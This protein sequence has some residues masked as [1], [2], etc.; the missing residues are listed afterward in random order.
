[1]QWKESG[2]VKYVEIVPA[3]VPDTC[4]RCRKWANKKI[5]LD[6]AIKENIL[7]IK[8]CTSMRGYCRCVYVP[9]VD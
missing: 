8:N 9:V 2:F 4:S 3:N 5:P 6:V 7:P 1:M